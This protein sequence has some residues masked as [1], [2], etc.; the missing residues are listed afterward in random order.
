MG[1]HIYWCV[2]NTGGVAVYVRFVSTS[3]SACEPIVELRHWVLH[4]PSVTL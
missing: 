1:I 3:L 4:Q 2:L